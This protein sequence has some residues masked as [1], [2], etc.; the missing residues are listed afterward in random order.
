MSNI[1]E[2]LRSI[3]DAGA[4][5][6]LMSWEEICSNAGIAA[7]EI[8]RLRAALRKIADDASLD[9]LHPAQYAREILGDE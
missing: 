2:R 5:V 1:V 3:S 9:V 6:H 7:N 8:E 4:I